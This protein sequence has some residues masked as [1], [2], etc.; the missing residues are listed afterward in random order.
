MLTAIMV[1]F[2]HAAGGILLGWGY[3]RR[4]AITRPP[5]GVFNLGDIAVMIAGI[6]LVPVLYLALPLWLV[7]GLLALGAA[8]VVYFAWEPVVR[9]RPLVWLI[10][11]GLVA[12]D[13]TAGLHWGVMSSGSL[14][15][16]NGVQVIMVVGITNLWAQSGMKARDV[17]LLG[18]ALM[19]YDFVATTLLGHMDQLFGRLAGLPL[20]PAFVWQVGDGRWLGLG[21]G[22]V[23]LAA[24][25][26][27]VLRKAFGHKAG[28]VALGMALA[29]LAVL[30]L[31]PLVGLLT[32]TF[33]VM[34]VLG[35]LMVLQYAYWHRR[36][37]PERTTW[38]YLQAEP[39]G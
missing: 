19:V 12:G 21:L 1:V 27:L 26:P 33:P 36:H 34:V 20:M 4:Y 18:A 35:P 9:S 17:A 2:L 7:V 15:L 24:V 5:I 14:L 23:L 6:I 30:L 37:G 28:L 16:N 31:A 38:Q 32:G 8:S 10:T 29:V 39:L 3:F 22:D 11:L 13:V 25:F